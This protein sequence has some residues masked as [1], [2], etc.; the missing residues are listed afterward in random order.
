MP[1]IRLS[2]T[3]YR[4]HIISQILSLG[5]VILSCSRCVK[6]GLVYVAIA[7]PFSRQPSSYSECTSINMRLSYNI[8]LMSNIK[9]IYTRL[10]SL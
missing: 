8:C 6:K 2:L 9:C 3:I 10:L 7:A 4:S 1:P 5:K